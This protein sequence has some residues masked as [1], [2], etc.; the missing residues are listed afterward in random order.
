MELLDWREGHPYS[1][2]F[3]DIYFSQSSGIKETRHVFLRNNHLARRWQALV[4]G[5]LFTIGE[6]GFGTGLNFL[7]AWQ[8]WR[9]TMPEKARL[10]FVST[11]KYPLGHADLGRA[12]AMWPELAA[13]SK[14]LLS[15]YDAASSGT[16]QMSFDDGRVTLTLLLGDVRE[17]LPQLHAVIDAWFLDGFAPAR[18][19]EMWQPEL[20]GTIARLSSRGATFATYT[21][22]GIVR[23]ALISAGFEVEKVPGFGTKRE[24]LR[25]TYIPS[26]TILARAVK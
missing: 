15:Q 17:T 21:C 2:L 10:H 14:L 8:L 3:G 26:T 11:E 7:C 13:L 24:M 23:R 16:Q 1:R 22:A 20:F 5:E 6:T 9:E 18:N 25:G 12:Q 19:P 4:P